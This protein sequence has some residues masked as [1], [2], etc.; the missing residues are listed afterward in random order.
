MQDSKSPEGTDTAR[1]GALRV[2]LVRTQHPGNIGS[3]A[4]AMKTMGLRDLALVAPGA[5]PDEQSFALA[6]GAADVIDRASSHPDLASAVADCAR[7]VGVTARRRGISLE[8]VDARA[9]AADWAGSVEVGPVALVFGAE[10]TGLTN[11]E[12]ALCQEAVQ[13]TADADYGSLN[14]AQ[15]VQVL[16]YEC[17]HAVTGGV[18]PRRR[19]RPADHA[20]MEGVYGHLEQMLVDID[21]LDPDNPRH[22][23]RRLRRLFARAAPDAVEANILRGIFSA[24]QAARRPR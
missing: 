12:L 13:I 21:F 16:A 22:L 7:V 24:V 10:R 18:T 8:V 23:M 11:E 15:A 1:L 14:L 5:P 4:R 2:V 17:R 20:V 9:W 19:R 3:T 6:A